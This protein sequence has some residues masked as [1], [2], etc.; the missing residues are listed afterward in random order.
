VDGS[1][2]HGQHPA[3]VLKLAGVFLAA[4]LVVAGVA[5]AALYLWLRTYAPLETTATGYAPGPGIGA[6]IEPAVGSGGKE[7]FFPA[8]RRGKP[9]DAAVTLRNAGHF[10]VTVE[11]LVA[12][13][14]GAPPWIGPVEAL[15][16]S[17]VSG[18]AD[19]GHTHP[20]QPLVLSP[21]DTGAIVVRFQPVCRSGRPSAAP[22]YVDRIRLRYGY[23]RIFDRVQTVELPF[24]VTLRCANGPLANP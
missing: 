7:V 15:G 19:V 23:L 24:A 9:F 20:F 5:A 10:T 12:A 17:S 8:Y 1:L 4:A 14:R 16:T 3:R 2:E 21:G 11:G 6:A 13:T 22:V 18:G